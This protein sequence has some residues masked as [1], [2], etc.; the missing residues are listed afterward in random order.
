MQVNL[1]G[2]GIMNK[3]D[4]IKELLKINPNAKTKSIAEEFDCS[5]TLVRVVR[6][7]KY[8]TPRKDAK[9]RCLARNQELAKRK[10][11]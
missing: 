1:A 4:L 7:G 6:T 10:R 8:I 5:E 9:A 11:R 2:V 3:V